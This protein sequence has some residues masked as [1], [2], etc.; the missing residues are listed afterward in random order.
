MAGVDGIIFSVACGLIALLL[1]VVAYFLKNLND[2]FKITAARVE[3]AVATLGNHR[4]ELDGIARDN[5]KHDAKIEGLEKAVARLEAR[6]E[7]SSSRLD[8]VELRQADW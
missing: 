2:D 7:V 5:G 4:V 1:A 3:L 8:Q 6:A